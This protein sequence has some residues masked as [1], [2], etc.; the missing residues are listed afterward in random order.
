MRGPSVLR[1]A[2]YGGPVS[3]TPPS[4][5]SASPDPGWWVGFWAWANTGLGTAIVGPV[6]VAILIA[7]F[8]SFPKVRR[9]AVRAL[10]TVWR[11]TRD[12]RVRRQSVLVDEREAAESRGRTTALAEVDAQRQRPHP[13][14]RWRI[15]L[16][17]VDDSWSQFWLKN[18]NIGAVVT[19]V[20]IDADVHTF[21]FHTE[22]EWGG[23][24][25]NTGWFAGRVVVPA[26]RPAVAEVRWYDENGDP[27]QTQVII[28]KS[29]SN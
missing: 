22:G 16:M 13:Q 7:L 12:L 25:T 29:V 24:F 11:F 10:R 8:A 9:P 14:P 4:P 5:T 2:Q 21:E 19:D 18:L 27:H 3:S 20:R 28:P 6:V 26:S 1:P 15:E 17:S 23:E